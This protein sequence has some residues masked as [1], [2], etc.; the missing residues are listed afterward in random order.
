MSAM[1]KKWVYITGVLLLQAILICVSLYFLYTAPSVGIST[2]WDKG[3]QRWKVTSAEPWS[4][5][6]EGDLIESIEGLEIGRIHL[7]KCFFYLE[8]RKEVLAWYHALKDLYKRLN[9]KEVSFIVTRGSG[10]L[11]IALQPRELRLSFLSPYAMMPFI[12][13]V[14][15][16]IGAAALYRKGI[17]E[18]SL[19]LFLMCSCT[20]VFYIPNTVSLLPETVMEPHF[21]FLIS[22]VQ[23]LFGSLAYLLMLHLS[24]LL[25]K[26][27]IVL[28]R[29]PRL[30]WLM[31]PLVILVDATLH[32][33]VIS[34]NV[35]CIC[36]L[37]VLATCRSYFSCANPVE[38]QQMKW[39]GAG[40][41]F[42]F[43]PIIVLCLIPV[44]LTGETLVDPSFAQIFS[45]L[46]PLFMAFA[47]HRF[48]LMGIDDLLH[49]TLIYMATMGLLIGIDL[50]FMGIFGV[51]FGGHL[52]LRQR[53]MA[54]LAFAI[55]ISLYA[56]LRERGRFFLRRLFGR[57]P[58]REREVLSAFTDG[59]LGQSPLS[60]A[61]CLESSIRNT[62][63]PKGLTLFEKGNG[64]GEELL[65]AF[66]GISDP[67]LLWESPLKEKAPSAD[68]LLALPMGRGQE[69][70]YVLFSGELPGGKLYG[71]HELRILRSLLRQAKLLY[72]NAWLYEEEKR[73]LSEKEK[74][75]RD[76][77]DG[78][79][80]I[81]TNIGLLAE[82]AR[83][84]PPVP[85]GGG[86]LSTI[87]QLSQ[88]GMSEIRTIMHSLDSTDLTWRGLVSELRGLGSR[89]IEPNGIA[90]EMEG[91][92]S[93]GRTRLG[94]FL[95]LNLLRIYKEALTNVI[96]HS[97]A[98]RV[99]VRAEIGPESIV[100]SIEDDGVGL[101]SKPYGGGRGLIN[102]EKR[103]R[104]IGGALS[105]QSGD[106]TRVH[107]EVATKH[108]GDVNG[109]V[110]PART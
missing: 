15:F 97:G 40:Y 29:F 79:G 85:E 32:M 14:F 74:I 41:L 33:T 28:R 77:H 104:D 71:S 89:M 6:K 47:I 98:A 44:I 69:V 50:G 59:A 100:L 17:D 8:D 22:I 52:D 94:S 37:A 76:L 75:F 65:S 11:R 2:A 56:V 63:R 43:S 20:A 18:Q 45:V 107:L 30:L 95:Y 35:L 38:K 9:Q 68:M 60:I 3:F 42:G 81:M 58:L 87:S 88:E 13:F 55:T 48:R 62:F 10:R 53:G 21:Q 34:L 25:P 96:K 105:I 109:E 73:H 7:I 66:R 26:R 82:I 31:Y 99:R 92:L 90:F 108:E 36:T 12:G 93:N 1:S 103:A 23:A 102:I 83:K 39:I 49:G 57:E 80:G 67:I 72:E 101:Q 106:G 110:V 86:P 5:L 64:V 4:G 46:L 91:I 84:S 16:I 27:N 24:L 78:I 54:M 70:D 51:R 19:V 61:K